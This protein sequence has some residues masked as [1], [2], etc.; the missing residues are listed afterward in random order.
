MNFPAK[1][2]FMKTI[3]FLAITLYETLVHTL[4]KENLENRKK[5][6]AIM[7]T[8]VHCSTCCLFYSFI[9]YNLHCFM[10]LKVEFS[11]E[12]INVTFMFDIID[13]CCLQGEHSVL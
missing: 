11:Q 7:M 1:K 9:L 10:D 8:F 4:P 13:S 5:S 3:Q 12:R 2:R 6:R